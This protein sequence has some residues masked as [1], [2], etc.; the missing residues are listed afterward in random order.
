MRSKPATF[1]ANCERDKL[2]LSPQES[3]VRKKAS[4]SQVRLFLGNCERCFDADLINKQTSSFWPAG[5]PLIFATAEIA[6][7]AALRLL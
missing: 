5:M 4:G 6:D 2:L 3:K 1:L 7:L